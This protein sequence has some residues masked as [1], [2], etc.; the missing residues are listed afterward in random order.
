MVSPSLNLKVSF[1]ISFGEAAASDISDNLT[2]RGGD[3]IDRTLEPH[4]FP[5]TD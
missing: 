5:I 2:G 4:G 1:C 3:K